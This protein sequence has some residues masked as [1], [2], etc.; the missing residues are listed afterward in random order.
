MWVEIFNLKQYP[1]ESHNLA[2]E[3]K[4]KSKVAMYVQ[5]CDSATARLYSQRVTSDD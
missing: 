2:F 1:N 4:Y 5:K 3:P